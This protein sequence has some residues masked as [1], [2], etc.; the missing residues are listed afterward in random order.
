M[1][2][3]LT[4]R[5]DST[6]L[7]VRTPDGPV[8]IVRSKND[9]QLIDGVLQPIIPAEG[10]EPVG[11]L[12]VLD[13]LN[14]P[15]FAVVDMRDPEWRR[16]GTVPGS[17]SIPF[18]EVVEQLEQLGCVKRDG[19]WDCSGAKKVVAFCNGPACPQS[20]VAVRAMIAAAFPP[21]RIY[22]YRGGMQDWVV[23]GLTTAA[24]SES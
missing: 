11:E 12:E 8:E 5:G 1:A 6:S 18:K 24:V 17:S 3:L 7:S 15:D 2:R 21:E 19:Q 23:L 13:A 9:T 16:R 14:D 20:S 4:I 22:Y 10:V